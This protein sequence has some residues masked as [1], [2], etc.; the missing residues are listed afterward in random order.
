MQTNITYLTLK[1]AQHVSVCLPKQEGGVDLHRFVIWNKTLCLRFI[2]LL[3]AGKESLW[4][5]W[6][7]T[8][9]IRGNSFWALEEKPF[10]T[11]TWRCLLRLRPLAERFARST[12]GNGCTTFFW[13]DS[14]T[15]FGPLIKFIGEDGPRTLWLPLNSKVSHACN[16][17]GWKLPPP[18]SDNALLLHTHLTLVPLPSQV[19]IDDYSSWVFGNDAGSVF[20]SSKSWD[21]LRPREPEKN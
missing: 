16:A 8:Q 15:P 12:V 3:F 21:I 18:R 1:K 14:W 9:H 11:W 4:A 19:I 10:D 6:H 17:V 7:I 5:S 2:W 13:H 20:S